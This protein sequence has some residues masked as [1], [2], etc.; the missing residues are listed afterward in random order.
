MNGQCVCDLEYLIGTNGTKCIASGTCDEGTASSNGT[1]CTCKTGYTDPNNN[2]TGCTKVNCKKVIDV[3]QCSDKKCNH[4]AGYAGTDNE[5]NTINC[6][7]EEYSNRQYV[8][9]D[10]L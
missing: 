6:G 1:A 8:S 2:A 10:G 7:T 3:I 5:C 9:E 4:A